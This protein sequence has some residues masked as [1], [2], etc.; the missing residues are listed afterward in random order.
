MRRTRIEIRRLFPPLRH[1]FCRIRATGDTSRSEL[2]ALNV[3]FG[4]P[5]QSI[6]HLP[7]NLLAFVISLPAGLEVF[8]AGFISLLHHCG[9]LTHLPRLKLNRC[10]GSTGKHMHR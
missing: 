5:G 10:D 2:R 9:V 3:I 4:W 6:V 7:T 8:A 1:H